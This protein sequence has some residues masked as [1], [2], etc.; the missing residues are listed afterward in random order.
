[1]GAHSQVWLAG[2]GAGSCCRPS[3]FLLFSWSLFAAAGPTGSPSGLHL[4]KQQHLGS[5]LREM[6]PLLVPSLLARA[7]LDA[8]AMAPADGRGSRWLLALW[9]SLWLS[10]QLLALYT[11]SFSRVLG[12]RGAADR[13]LA[14]VGLLHYSFPLSQLSCGQSNS[15]RSLQ[16][17]EHGAGLAKSCTEPSAT[18]CSAVGLEVQEGER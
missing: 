1:M 14:E 15:Q 10:P 2:K 11:P 17:W 16:P 9:F 18:C 6:S 8:P 13:N 12:N 4:G 3:S 5:C 7:C